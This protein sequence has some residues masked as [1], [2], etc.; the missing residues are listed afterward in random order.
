MVFTP[1]D[2]IQVSDFFNDQAFI[3][4]LPIPDDSTEIIVRQDDCKANIFIHGTLKTSGLFE[5][6]MD[7]TV[8]NYMVNLD[9]NHLIIW[10][11]DGDKKWKD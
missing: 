11:K 3:L 4:H 7:C 1:R 6:Y 2:S 9:R 8:Y 10:I 5:K